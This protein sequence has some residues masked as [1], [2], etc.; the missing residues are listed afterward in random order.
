MVRVAPGS[1]TYDYGGNASKGSV[2]RCKCPKV[3]AK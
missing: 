3:K 1:G 2:H